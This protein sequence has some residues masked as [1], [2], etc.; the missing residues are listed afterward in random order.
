MNSFCTVCKNG[1]LQNGTVTVTLE[2]NDALLIFKE[3]PALVCDNCAAYFLDESMSS[4]LYQKAE[5]A[6][7]K[8]TQLE[9]MKLSA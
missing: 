7:K 1:T 2:R 8:G 3:V 9:V 5:E 6:I 4:N